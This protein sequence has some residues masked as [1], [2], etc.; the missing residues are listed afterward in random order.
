MTRRVERRTTHPIELSDAT[1]QQTAINVANMFYSS[2]LCNAKYWGP[3]LHQISIL[4]DVMV[5]IFY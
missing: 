2:E 5:E 4:N 1:N 3:E